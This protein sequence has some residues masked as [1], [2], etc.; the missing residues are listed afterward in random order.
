MQYKHALRILTGK[1]DRQIN[2]QRL[3][4]LRIWAS[5]PLVQQIKSL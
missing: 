2:P 4:K 3:Q 5:G 1:N